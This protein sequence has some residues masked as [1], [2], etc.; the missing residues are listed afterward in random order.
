[1]FSYSQS[2]Q[3]HSNLHIHMILSLFNPIVALVPQTLSPL[4]VHLHLIYYITL[5]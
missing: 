5:R 1:M 3:H 2:P 4:L